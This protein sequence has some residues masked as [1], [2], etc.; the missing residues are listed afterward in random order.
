M[1]KKFWSVV[2]YVGI[3]FLLYLVFGEKFLIGGLTG[4]FGVFLM[5]LFNP[6]AKEHPDNVGTTQPHKKIRICTRCKKRE[7]RW[8]DHLCEECLKTPVLKQ[9][10]TKNKREQGFIQ[11]PVLIYILFGTLVAT[12]GGYY[13]V[14]HK[15]ET[16][17]KQNIIKSEDK[18]A[19]TS[20]SVKPE[21]VAQI[22]KD[23]P[24]K[25]KLTLDKVKQ[26]T[27]TKTT[28]KKSEKTKADF[29]EYRT[30]AIKTVDLIEQDERNFK[31]L[32]DTIIDHKK[33]SAEHARQMINEWITLVEQNIASVSSQYSGRLKTTKDYLISDR[34]WV[35]DYSN[36]MYDIVFNG[37]YLLE[38]RETDA[39][40]YV[41][42]EIKRC[43][44]MDMEEWANLNGSAC[45]TVLL[46]MKSDY[47]KQLTN[48]AN[49]LAEV[50]LTV[51]E[52]IGKHTRSA[53]DDV[54][55]DM[56][57]IA[58]Y[59]QLDASIRT[60][61]DSIDRQL[62]QSQAQF[63]AANTPIK[64]YTST[65]GSIFDP[66]RTYSTTCKPYT[67]TCDEK[68]AAWLASGGAYDP[69]SKPVCN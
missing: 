14:K 41:K 37:G 6:Q 42:G 60:S 54:R 13:A 46:D 5:W 27:E 45:T 39:L 66:N 51:L 2:L 58:R 7:G 57:T 48:G 32:S 16:P 34:D 12:G 56:D 52:T 30:R 38:K 4:L 65:N 25:P 36:S 11:I 64:C 55:G 44:A 61:A 19:T 18:I 43:L 53:E 47:S 49:K 63:Q 15:S 17:I 3:I 20:E 40:D 67:Q 68:I 33:R 59:E 62:Q 26:V 23:D 69:S 21:V 31:L 35:V 9:E 1:N 50:D 8:W 29:D 22:K 10:D 28:P 24:P